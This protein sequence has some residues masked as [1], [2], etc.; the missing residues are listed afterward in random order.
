MV[1]NGLDGVPWFTGGGAQHSPNIA[2]VLAHAATSGASGII[3][4]GDFK[5]S[6][7]APTADNN[8][9]VGV[10]AA[11]IVS[12]F[13]NVQ[14]ESYIVRGAAVSD[15]QIS[16]T[17]SSGRSDLVIL[18]VKDPQFPGQPV[19]SSV[20]NGP[21]VFPEIIPGVPANTTRIEQLN[22]PQAIYAPARI[23][24]PPNTTAI[25]AGMIKDLRELVAPHGSTASDIQQPPSKLVLAKTQTAYVDWPTNQ[26]NVKIPRRAT[27][28]Q[29]VV[30]GS[31][32]GF[33]PGPTN[34]NGTADVW[35]RVLLNGQADGS[36]YT[37]IGHNAWPSQSENDG[38]TIPWSVFGEFDVR[39]LQG[40]S[41]PIRVQGRRVLEAI[42]TGRLEIWDV[43]PVE[44]DV[45]FT[46]RVV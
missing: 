33:G 23:D 7:S 8:I 25:T 10:G 18:K 13:A 44:F 3:T 16:P 46:E 32:I 43:F 17:G 9:H 24:I 42:A 45:R 30:R 29:V 35:M 14:S 12:R 28:A 15:I 26:L 39:A 36:R 1:A 38:I 37:P 6:P 5:V 4:P 22:L 34:G 31:M 21:Y 41:V 27:H 2:R 40:Q 19:P 11:A 20:P